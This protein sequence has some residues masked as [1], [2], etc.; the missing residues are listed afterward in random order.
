MSLKPKYLNHE[1]KSSRF[2]ALVLALTLLA[3]CSI[4]PPAESIVLPDPI[5][6]ELSADVFCRLDENAVSIRAQGNVHVPKGTVVI[7]ATAKENAYSQ[8]HLAVTTLGPAAKS[9]EQKPFDVFLEFIIEQ[10]RLYNITVAAVINRMVLA[11]D[12]LLNSSHKSP[13][14]AV[15]TELSFTCPTP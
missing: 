10:G 6:N 12:E 4:P 11:T 7:V 8:K 3:A 13:E 14:P 2:I 1:L 5:V 9:P 15:E